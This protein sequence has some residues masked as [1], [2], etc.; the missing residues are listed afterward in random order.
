MK[1]QDIALP[2][3]GSPASNLL[4]AGQPTPDDFAALAKAGVR[5]VVDLRPDAEDHG[6]DEA[7]LTAKLGM[8]RTVIPVASA[9]DLTTD[10]AKKLDAAIAAAG[11][12]T[13]LIHCAS[14]NRVGGLLAVRANKIQGKSVDEALAFGRAGGLTKMEPQVAE[15]LARK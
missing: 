11:G 10:N 9:A 8:S 3:G 1:P 7:A 13:V 12:G 6:F 14:S 4:T 2:L 5:H 15:I